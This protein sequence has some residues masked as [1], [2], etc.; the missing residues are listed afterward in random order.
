MNHIRQ[1]QKLNEEE[2][3]N[4]TSISASWHQE[5]NDTSYIYIGSLPFE[6]TE[7]DILTIFSQFGVPTDLKM[8]RDEDSGK[9]K[10]FCFLKYEDQ[11]STV[12][13]IDNLNGVQVGSRLIRV[14]HARYKPPKEPE[15]EEEVV[16]GGGGGGENVNN[17][18]AKQYQDMVNDELERDFANVES[19]D[20]IAKYK[21][22]EKIRYNPRNDP[23]NN[24]NLNNIRNNRKDTI[25]IDKD[26]EIENDHIE[27]E[28]EDEFEDPMAK[29]LENKEKTMNKK[30]T[31]DDQKSYKLNRTSGSKS[32][33][34]SHNNHRHHHHHH[35]HRHSRHRSDKRAKT[36][37]SSYSEK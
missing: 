7:L 25:P 4:G 18:L 13:A 1:V 15:T 35:H 36:S 34:R 12:L 23:N 3:K 8:A 29:F 6:I 5:Y 26:N 11:R 27:D 10:G 28:E 2:L 31:L 16:G 17:N 24:S 30:R 22:V 21:A 9:S 14:D 37:D 32:H 33:R 20:E 19:E